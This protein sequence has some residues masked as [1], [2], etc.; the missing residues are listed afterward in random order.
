MAKHAKRI[1]G[2]IGTVLGALGMT[3]C[4][5]VIVGAWWINGPLT[6]GLLTIFPPIE[7]ALAFGDTTAERFGTFVG[8][9]QTQLNETANAKPVATALADEIEQAAV[10]VNVASGLASSAEETLS[11]VANAVQPGAPSNVA[12]QASNRLSTTM[13]SASETLNSAEMLAQDV[14]DGRTEKVDQLNNQLDLLEANAAEVQTAISQ[15]SDDVAEIK[16]KL[17]RWVNLGSLIV[18]LIFLWFGF[19]QYLLMHSGWRWVRQPEVV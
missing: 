3:L 16:L 11:G 12:T 2:F 1:V 13:D 18:T 9:A 4:L 8:D 14:R 7:A 19:A 10:Y 5:A 6:D 15:T 17:P